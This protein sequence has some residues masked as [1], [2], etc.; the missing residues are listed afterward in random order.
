MDDHNLLNYSFSSESGEATHNESEEVDEQL[1]K[2]VQPVGAM[3]AIESPSFE[4]PLK[5][6]EDTAMSS[7]SPE[8]IEVI[9]EEEEKIA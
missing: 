6:D 8:L 2:L 1:L 4:M 3:E 5:E 9:K 7:F